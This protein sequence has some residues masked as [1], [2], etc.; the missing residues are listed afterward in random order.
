MILKSIPKS[1]KIL[2]IHSSGDFYSKQYFD[3]WVKVAKS[4]PDIQFF[5]YTKGLQYVSATKP[6]NLSLIY[7]YGGK[8]DS[9]LTT[10]PVSYVVK[11]F[12]EAQKLGLPVVCQESMSDDYTYI[13][14]GR[15]FALMIHGTQPA[16][17]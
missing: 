5:A 7:S 6:D 11:S 8:L 14:Q 10:E 12:D 4:R 16:K 9:K 3:A 13:V 15:S 1:V 2:R 17:A